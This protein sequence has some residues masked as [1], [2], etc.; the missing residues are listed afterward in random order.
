MENKFFKKIALGLGVTA[1]LSSS[2]P[3]KATGQNNKDSE[4]KKPATTISISDQEKL[5]GDQ[6]SQ[7]E[8]SG[9]DILNGK[10]DLLQKS[11]TFNLDYTLR[12]GAPTLKIK[13]SVGEDAYKTYSSGQ[14]RTQTPGK[15]IGYTDGHYESSFEG[16]KTTPSAH[17]GLSIEG[18]ENP[19]SMFHP[20]ARLEPGLTLKDNSFV[21]SVSLNPYLKFDIKNNKKK[22]GSIEGGTKVE[23]PFISISGSNPAENDMRRS[24][25]LDVNAYIKGEADLTKNL[26]VNA[27]LQKQIS[28]DAFGKV[29]LKYTLGGKDKKKVGHRKY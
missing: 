21:G 5:S 14:V 24:G 4:D 23:V 6:L 29:G 1:A 17:I 19:K 25:L 9:A 13:G 28:G 16:N 11:K 22:Y 26:S 7:D 27:S 20:N 8:M 15:P 12:E 3:E 2:L 18:P 10:H